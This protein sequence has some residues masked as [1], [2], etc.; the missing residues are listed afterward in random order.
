[1]WANIAWRKGIKATLTFVAIVVIQLSLGSVY[2]WSVFVP[3]LMEMSAL[4]AA[5]CQLVFGVAIAAFAVSMVWAGRRIQ[6]YGARWVALI[7]VILYSTGWL[8]S[9]FF[10]GHLFVLLAGVGLV[11]GAGIGC[12]YVASLASGVRWFP[13]HKGLVTGIAVAGFGGGGAILAVPVAALLRDHSVGDVFRWLALGYALVGS[14][15]SL[16]LFRAPPPVNEGIPYCPHNIVALCRDRGFR[17]LAY[18]MFGGTFAGLL[19]IGNLQA[20]GL[21]GGLADAS[22]AVSLFAVGNGAGR[23]AWGWLADRW[24][25]RTHSAAL[26]MLGVGVLLLLPGR[27]D[28]RW[29]ALAALLVGLGFAACFVVYAAEVAVRYGVDAVEW[30]YPLLFLI[31]G[32]SG[33]T[34]PAVGGWLY[35]RC[36]G[37]TLPVL[38]AALLSLMVA[39]VSWRGRHVLKIRNES[40]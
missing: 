39:F 30:V 3:P 32:F 2:I 21:A 14:A 13:N 35:E 8:I 4:T 24:G 9:A 1:M 16:L 38:M 15:C 18:G 31:Y 33:L 29:F 12:G 40:G 26:L 22:A 20:I 36:N 7:G 17:L 6:R 19:V 28:A 34:G 27:A 5:Q 10:P 25:Y 23:I 11:G 37:Y